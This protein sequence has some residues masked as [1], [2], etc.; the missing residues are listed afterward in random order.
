VNK[1]V[2]QLKQ[3][4]EVLLN[5]DAPTSAQP[6]EVL[7]ALKTLFE[8]SIAP[9]LQRKEER[10][11]GKYTP[12]ALFLQKLQEP[13]ITLQFSEIEKILG[14][15]LPDSA[16][17]YRAWWANDVTHSQ[18]RAWTAVHW[19][20]SEVDL[21]EKRVK[22]VRL[23]PEKEP[24]YMSKFQ[25]KKIL[26]NSLGSL[27]ST[28]NGNYY[29]ECDTSEGTIAVWGSPNNKKNIEALQRRS[30]PFFATVSCIPGN[31][32]RHTYWVPEVTE[33]LFPE[34]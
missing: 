30:A 20:T 4:D 7:E 12:L 29:L 1:L 34:P 15:A 18:A 14:F 11:F 2:V 5:V 8:G 32:D 27:R 19:Q 13:T 24:D 21:A 28:S 33:I 3:G 9:K 23:S 25:T 22:F 10:N 17:G 6:H 16:E 31:W 26:V